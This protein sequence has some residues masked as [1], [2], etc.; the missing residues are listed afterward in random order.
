MIWDHGRRWRRRA[1][2][3]GLGPLAA[4]RPRALGPID[5]AEMSGEAVERH[6][7]ALFSRRGYTV[8][9][10]PAR[11]GAGAELLLCRGEQ[12][13]VVQVKRW[14]APLGVEVVQAAIDAMSVHAGLL[15]RLGCSRIGG[16]V[17]S[18]APFKPEA[19]E[20][21][22]RFGVILWDR[23]ALQTQLQPVSLPHPQ[24]EAAV[25][26]VSGASPSPAP[27][28]PATAAAETAAS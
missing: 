20:L 5:F 9:P 2:A 11:G 26:S 4:A 28:E 18:N 21:A 12:G 3:A 22:G 16:L 8:W 10:T 14:N 17:V 27:V 19:R 7:T 15:H 13:V 1:A 23:D 25:A 24:P 6:L